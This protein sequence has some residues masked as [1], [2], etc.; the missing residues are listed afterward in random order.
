M[1][2]KAGQDNDAVN[3]T[4]TL[5]HTASGGDYVNVTKDLPISITDDDSAAVVLSETDLAVTEGDAAGST[6]TV[7]L[8]TQPS[9]TVS[10]SITGQV[11]TD[12]SLSGTT[13]NSN[14]LTFTVEN[15]NTA[16]TVTVK[17]G[18]D[19]DGAVNDTA[20]LTHTASGGDYVNVTKDL[21]VSIT[22]DDTADIVLS[23]TDLTVTEGVAAGSSYT[24]KLATQPTGEVTV[25][26]SG[27]AGTDLTLDKT[28]LTFTTDNWNTAQTVT[29]K[30]GQDN[31]G[32]ADTATL[33]HTASGG[34]YV[35]V[36]KD[37]PVS[38][39]DDDA[40]DILFSEAD[41]TVTEE[42]AAGSSYTVKLATQP[43]ATV[44]LTIS[45][46]DGTDLSIDK[47]SLTF[48]VDDWDTVQTVTV[49]AGQDNDAVNDTA[50]LTH[51]ASGGDYVNVT[52]DLPVSGHRRRHSGHRAQR[53]GPHRDG[54][55]TPWG[56]ATR[57]RW[58]PSP[59][60]TVTVTVSGHDG[61]GSDAERDD[62]DQQHAD[63]HHGQLGHRADGDGQGG[64]GQRRRINDTAT[65]THTA[66]GGDY[67]NVT[68]GPAGQQ[69]PTMTVRISCSAR[70]IVT[71]TEGDAA[72]TSYTVKLATQPS[73]TVIGLHLRDMTGTDL[74]AER[75]PR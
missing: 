59:R 42:D 15:W 4:A 46:H 12:L 41:V 52:K 32:S 1:T 73:G 9:G 8:A 10:V 38:I 29:V 18:Q 64:S 35:N 43:S 66:S 28:T 14:M 24:V 39:T 49:K 55:R 68:R 45:G 61:H 17:A 25:T 27:H 40:A 26:V 33:T 53:D 22:D 5:T 65:L 47:T 3:D 50:T 11:S 74:N 67:V 62:V 71:L 31:D 23:E 75:E 51:T 57:W 19:N 56:R 21:P 16:Q 63:I 44:N 60:A 48:T 6:Y 34:D 54:G 70:R 58:T 30:A 69:S 20:T 72:G 37:L 2:V 13:L 36:T 7:K